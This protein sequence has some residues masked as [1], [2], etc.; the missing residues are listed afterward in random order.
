MNKNILLGMVMFTLALFYANSVF[1]GCGCGG[2]KG[3]C[4]QG[5]CGPNCAVQKDMRM[6]P[7]HDM[8]M[9]KTGSAKAIDVGNKI[10]PVMG[11]KIDPKSKITYEYNGKIYHF[12]CPGCIEEFKKNP[13][14]YIRIIEQTS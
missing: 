5:G 8:V 6:C 10:C 13:E 4:S 11:D 9:A 1:A 3:N 2:C 12:C 7:A 14:K